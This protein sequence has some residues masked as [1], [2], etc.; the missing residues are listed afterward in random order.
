M[1]KFI[2]TFT[3]VL[4]CLSIFGAC[5]KSKILQEA[6]DI[7]NDTIKYFEQQV[8]D[9][10]DKANNETD[11]NMKSFYQKMLQQSKDSLRRLQENNK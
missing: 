1:R 2:A 4:A 10:R 9:Y 11:P 7:H 5:G 3:L 8:E 6:E